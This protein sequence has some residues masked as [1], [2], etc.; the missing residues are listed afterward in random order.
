LLAEDRTLKAE[1]ERPPSSTST[2]SAFRDNRSSR[3]KRTVSLHRNPTQ[4]SQGQRSSH[5]SGSLFSFRFSA[6]I[7]RTTTH[8]SYDGPSLQDAGGLLSSSPASSKPFSP[9]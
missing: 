7:I 9:A 1:K 6:P 8:T 5:D 4:T 2:E 3:H